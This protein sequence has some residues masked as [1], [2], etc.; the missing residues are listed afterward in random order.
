[1]PASDEL[2]KQSLRSQ[3]AGKAGL[4]FSL[5]TKWV[6]RLLKVFKN[7]F[8]Y[9]VFWVHPQKAVKGGCEEEIKAGDYEGVLSKCVLRDFC[10]AGNRGRMSTAAP[11]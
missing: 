2:R 5:S 8:N 6:E 3:R 10:H 4:H 9:L 11:E 1:M 7:Y